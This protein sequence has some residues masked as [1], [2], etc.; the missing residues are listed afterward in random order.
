MLPK[1]TLV[2]EVAIGYVY[3]LTGETGT[4]KLAV[5]T[6]GSVVLVATGSVVVVATGSVVVWAAGS[7]LVYAGSVVEVTGS[8]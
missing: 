1:E 2:G 8:V 6:P 5:D 3:L 7:V 4:P